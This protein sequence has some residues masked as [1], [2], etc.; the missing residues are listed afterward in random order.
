MMYWMNKYQILDSL[1]IV[2]IIYVIAWK[3]NPIDNF[4]MS[5]EELEAEQSLAALSQATNYIF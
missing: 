2:R 1:H 5:R 4:Y 3:Y